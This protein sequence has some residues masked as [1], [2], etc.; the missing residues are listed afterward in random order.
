MHTHAISLL[1][2]ILAKG[3]THIQCRIPRVTCNP[4]YTLRLIIHNFYGLSHNLSP[5]QLI[6]DHQPKPFIF[7]FYN[8]YCEWRKM[9]QMSNHD[10]KTKFRVFLVFIQSHFRKPVQTIFLS[11]IFFSRLYF[12]QRNNG[13]FVFSFFTTFRLKTQIKKRKKKILVAQF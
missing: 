9:I 5:L 4:N 6:T 1:G 10:G 3:V 13:A 7:D 2:S 12:S 11:L 8:C